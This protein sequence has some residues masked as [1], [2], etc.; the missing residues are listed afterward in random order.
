MIILTKIKARH[1]YWPVR[2][3]GYPKEAPNP[4]YESS[5][6]S[7]EIF[8]GRPINERHW[9]FLNDQQDREAAYKMIEGILAEYKKSKASVWDT[10]L[11]KIENF[12]EWLVRY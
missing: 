5:P 3:V 4:D 1:K 2:I 11:Y 8:F 7:I 12:A 6:A 9:L 10:L